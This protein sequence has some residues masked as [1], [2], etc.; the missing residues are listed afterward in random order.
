MVDEGR[1]NRV[2]ASFV[3]LFFAAL[4]ALVVFGS[5]QFTYANS[6]K[7]AGNYFDRQKYNKAYH[8]VSGLEIKMKDEE[9]YNKI[10]TVMFVNK[11]LNSY[12]NYFGIQHYEEA[13]D[14]L[15]KG[16]KR[17]DKYI[18]LA[19]ELGIE[20]DLRY[21]RRQ[22]LAELKRTYNITEKKALQLN[23]IEDQEEYSSKVIHAAK[24]VKK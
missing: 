9:I 21:V 10:M 19:R 6:I 24:V 18:A 1:I 22:I 2:G 13:L 12:N 7:N 8:E 16:L 3:F 20:S 5:N 23:S 15:L 14:S 17:Y 11:E 4:A